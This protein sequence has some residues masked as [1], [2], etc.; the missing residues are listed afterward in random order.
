MKFAGARA[1]VLC[2]CFAAIHLFSPSKAA[3]AVV[4]TMVGTVEEGSLNGGDLAGSLFTYNAV[5]TNTTDIDDVYPDIG[6]FVVD[7]AQLDF[8]SNRVYDFGTQPGYFAWGTQDSAMFPDSF[9]AYAFLSVDVPNSVYS[10]GFGFSGTNT[11][12]TGFD[13]NLL[14]EFGPFDQFDQSWTFNTTTGSFSA[15]NGLGDTLVLS[16]LGTNGILAV[17]AVPEPSAG[18]LVFL[19]FG[20]S[21]LRGNR[22]S[23][24]RI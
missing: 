1:F 17:T 16:R 14:G 11:S 2:V 19:V 12:L 22:S 20:T 24:V 9:Y 13:P 10:D 21:L 15:N 8:G 5:I 7:F 23:R 3:A 6:T 4:V 18:A